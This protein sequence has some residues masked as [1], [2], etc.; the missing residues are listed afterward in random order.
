MREDAVEM[1]LKKISEDI[2]YIKVRVD[3]NNV[4]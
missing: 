2:S 4:K 1:T 3:D